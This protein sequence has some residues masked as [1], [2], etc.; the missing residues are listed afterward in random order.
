MPDA[1]RVA[2]A[3]TPPI[4]LMKSNG[5]GS[6]SLVAR[7]AGAIKTA[8]EKSGKDIYS[9]TKSDVLTHTD[10]TEWQ[11]RSVGGVSAVR[12]A[13]YPEESVDLPGRRAVAIRKSYVNKLEREAGDWRYYLDE[14]GR[15]IGEVL[16]EN[17]IQVAKV[18]PVHFSKKPGD[19]P[20]EVVAYISDT[21]FGLQID[22][23]EVPANRYNWQVAARRMGKFAEQVATYKIEHRGATP[24]LRLCLGGD[25]AQGI[26][27][28]ND[29]GTDLITNQVVGTADILTKLID[30]L[31]NAYSEILVE[32]VPCNHLRL[33][34]KGP[35]RATAQ[36]WDAFSTM[37]HVMLQH[38]YR[39]T[40]QVKFNVPK[41]PWADFEVLGHRFFMTHG[42]TTLEVGN[43]GAK[44]D[45]ERITKSVNSLNA[46][47]QGK[48]YK[49]VMVGHVHTPMT[50]LLKN[51]VHL[52]VNGTGSGTDSFAQSLGIY[53][54]FAVQTIFEATED[55]AVGD[56]RMILLDDADENPRYEAII[57][58]WNHGL[59][60]DKL[61]IGK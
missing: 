54:S 15:K 58:P 57:K 59:V 21:H 56:Y 25:L 32:A 6:T 17:P 36:K 60:L 1:E 37:I 47:V 34:H 29:A 26:I 61:K 13:H 45:N 49:V 24:R 48:R 4:F 22:P 44:I 20:R 27:H 16:E 9:V 50:M 40:D 5:P 10:V 55:F 12:K 8:A 7:V 33:P 18:K 39:G 43:V 14:V 11:I 51:G 46:S 31:R 52:I 35:D 19:K 3:T 38:A 28:L 53:D 23:E 42:D 30:Y 2:P 41:T